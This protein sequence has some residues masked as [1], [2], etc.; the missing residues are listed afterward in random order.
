MARIPEALTLA[1]QHHQAGRLQSAEQIYRQILAVQPQH[2]DSLHLLGVI[3][4]QSGQHA[5]AIEHIGQAIVLRGNEACYHNN[6]GE[7]YRAASRLAEADACYQRA[8]ELS[9]GY[10]DAHNNLGVSMADQGKLEEAVACFRRALALNAEFVLAHFNLGNI[11]QKQVKLNDA[12]ACYRRA[13]ELKPNYAEAYCNLGVVLKE[14]GKIDDAVA[15]YRRALALRPDFAE[16]LCN[17][18]DAL[19]AQGKLEEA[20]ACCRRAVELK[21]DRAAAYNN[22]AN[23]LWGQGRPDEAAACCAKALA[24]SPDFA[25]AHN[26]LGNLLRDQGKLEQAVASYRKAL[27]L[28]PDYADALG[29]FGAV[30]VEQGD[31]PGAAHS[32]RAALRCNPRFVFAHGE[33]AKLLRDR[34]PEA[35]LAA[36]RGLLEGACI[37][38]AQRL[39]LHFGL[40]QVLDARSEYREAAEHLNWANQ[41]QLSEW[42]KR[43][44][45]YDPLDHESRIERMMEICTEEF[46]ARTHGF[47][48][49]S[50]VPVFIV[51]LPRSG[52][53]LIEQILAAHPQVFAAGEIK[54][55]GESFA[56]LGGNGLDAFEGLRRVDHPTAQQL[57]IRQ[58]EQLRAFDSS[59]F[60]I[61]DKMPDNYLFLGLLA[62]LFPRAKLI[63]CR[64]DL[65]DVAISCWMTHFQN[66][67]WANDPQHIATRFYQHERIIEHWRKALPVPL[68]ELRYEETVADLEGV[69]RKLVAWCG[70]DWNPACLNFHHAKRPVRTA[71]T[72][73]VR[74]PVYGTSVGRW[75]HYEDHLAVL[76]NAIACADQENQLLAGSVG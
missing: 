47:G 9:P 44:K 31:L 19:N 29:N 49:D 27:K 76:L 55:A 39:L 17:L 23:V 15:C 3:L 42:R 25:E 65:R 53:T 69:A 33:L 57:A 36:L 52:T 59:S 70:L 18:G 73:Q 1:L 66:I 63:Y 5:A 43:S 30:L 60:R 4:S 13:L 72:V 8:L 38:D 12:I 34:L 41:L 2:P 24:L 26:N 21:P 40:A 71:S 22:L 67:R 75:R 68:L 6:L 56:S 45:E 11:L 64:R 51:G 7:A 32:F 10:V 48:L 50:E 16:A 61:V 58:L 37:P 46:F 28:K 74:Q 62:C 20:V 54:F 14:Q 35:D